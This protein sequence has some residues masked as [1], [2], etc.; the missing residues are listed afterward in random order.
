VRSGYGALRA[1]LRRRRA[2]RARRIH[3]LREEPPRLRSVPGSEHPHLLRTPRP[4]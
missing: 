3:A 2:E 4:F 1:A